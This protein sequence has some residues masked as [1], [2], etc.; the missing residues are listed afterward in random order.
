[1]KTSENG[2]TKQ[3]TEQY[4]VQE[5]TV[6]A[7]EARIKEEVAPFIKGEFYVKKIANKKY[8]DIFPSN[9]NGDC[10]FYNVKSEE[11]EIDEK[12]G[13][14]KKKIQNTLIQAKSLDLAHEKFL[15]NMRG[16]LIDFEIVS[17]TKTAIVDC[18][19]KKN[20]SFKSE[21]CISIYHKTPLKFKN[22][23]NKK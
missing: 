3:T 22:N 11:S 21:N 10:Y 8:K 16:T 2:V 1:M 5:E 15:N 12:S 13:K 9:T 6:S 19:S 20:N 17:I 18:Y 23:E 4:I 7:A 14:E